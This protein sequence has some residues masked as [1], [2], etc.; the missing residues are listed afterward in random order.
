MIDFERVF[1]RVSGVR[2]G[3]RLGIDVGSVRVGVARS[4]PDGMLATPLVTLRRGRGDLAELAA[5]VAD[6]EAVEVVVGL[7]R[8]LAGPGGQRGHGRDV[9]R[10][11]PRR[12]AGPGASRC[13]W[14]T[15]G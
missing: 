2:A 5:L 6:S 9:V 15:S 10:A 14:S 1:E 11:A 3:V 7:P 8:T 13:A 4:D 12:P